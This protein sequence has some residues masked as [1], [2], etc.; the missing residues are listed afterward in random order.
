[1]SE[2]K[3]IRLM[4][5]RTFITSDLGESAMPKWASWVKV[6]ADGQFPLDICF[7]QYAHIFNYSR[8][9]ASQR[10]AGDAPKHK[11]PQ[12]AET[13]HSQASSSTHIETRT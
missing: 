8:R 4:V 9:S 3:D 1:M 10:I 2:S 13:G 7:V 6:V 11:I 5:K 12:D